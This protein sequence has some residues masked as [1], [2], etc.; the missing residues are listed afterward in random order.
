MP[1]PDRGRL[2]EYAVKGGHLAARQ[3][4]STPEQRRARRLAGE[5]PPEPGDGPSVAILT[6]RDWTAHVQWEAMIAQALRLR[7]A[8]VEFLTC[9]GGLEVC[10]RA[11]T[12]EGPPMPCTSCTRYVEDSVD[13]HGF[14][15]TS[16]RD[17]WER[18][19]PGAW[20]ELDEVSLAAL[21][22]VV[23]DDGLPY[24]RLTEIPVKWF[25][26][27]A[28]SHDDPLAPST[29]R[30]FLRSARRIA[31][32]VEAALDR[33]RPDVVLLCNGL[34]LFEA[35]TWEL[36]RRR[37]IDVVTY[38]RGFIKET[39]V[40]RRGAPACLTELH[41]L[42][43]R[44]ADAALTPVEEARLD[45]YLDARRHGRRTIDRYWDDARFDAPERRGSGRLVTLFTNLTWDSAVIGKERAYPSIQAWI[46]AAVEAF[47]ARPDHE[48]VIRLHPA[49]VKLPGKWTREPMADVLRKHFPTLPA[50]VRVV[51]PEDPTSSYPLMEA[52]DL[53]LV[54]TST[55]G[56]ELALAGV[57][58]IVAGETHY[59]GK[60][61]T[62]DVST[63]E[64]FVAA[65]DAA[66]DDP[67]QFAPDPQVARR[68]AN[69][70]F[71]AAPVPSPGVEEHVP[72]LA[73]ITVEH[74]DELAPGR[75]PGVDRI[76]DGILHGGDFLAP[77]VAPVVGGAPSRS[78]RR[79]VP[80]AVGTR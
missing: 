13:A 21:R 6:P 7:G 30:A 54:F 22:D 53:G 60:G 9:G 51:E 58:V 5:A 43:P 68:Y 36:C 57:P 73:R 28:S 33:I 49:E 14:D 56:L 44:F 41:D 35:V 78:G 63:P 76:C 8:R 42:W 64:E 17:G 10:D 39:L 52:S 18:D 26:M 38:E 27:R 25:L 75:H 55:T 80:V 20:D 1:L 62:V 66:L 12:W 59:R 32:G 65:L 77:V 46:V 11:N 24:G 15:R 69:L 23:G 31:A 4:A 67:G 50:N 71:F 61:F 19:D 72:G 3:V 48:L 79:G 2:R 47:A 37:G 29:W 40:F 34:F 74:L 16:L 70:F 45:D